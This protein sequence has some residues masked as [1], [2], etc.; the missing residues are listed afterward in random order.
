[1][2]PTSSGPPVAA[3]PTV[4]PLLTPP[5]EP[6]VSRI[7]APSSPGAASSDTPLASTD[8]IASVVVAVPTAPQATEG[9]DVRRRL[10]PKTVSSYIEHSFSIRLLK[11]KSMHLETTQSERFKQMLGLHYK[12]WHLPSRE[13]QRLLSKGG[14]PKEIVDLVPL[15]LPSRCNERMQWKSTITKPIAGGGRLATFF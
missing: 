8:I 13:T 1:M 4:D 7:N 12:L 9:I 6:L 3:S 10:R 5:V 11:R 2:A 14:Y 15:V